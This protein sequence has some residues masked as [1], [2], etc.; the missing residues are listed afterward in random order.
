[1]IIKDFGRQLE[2]LEIQRQYP[3]KELPEAVMRNVIAFIWGEE[4]EGKGKGF[5]KELAGYEK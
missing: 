2:F 3:L 5:E 1:M 4:A